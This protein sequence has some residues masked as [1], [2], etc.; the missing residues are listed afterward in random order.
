[1][2]IRSG[3]GDVSSPVC[4]NRRATCRSVTGD[5]TSPSATLFTARSKLRARTTDCFG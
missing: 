5:I 2:E 1:M 3:F 4:S